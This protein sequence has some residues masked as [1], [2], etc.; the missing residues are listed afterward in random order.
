MKKGASSSPGLQGRGGLVGGGSSLS[1]VVPAGEDQLRPGRTHPQPGNLWL[2]GLIKELGLA[3]A[4]GNGV[5]PL[6]EEHVRPALPSRG[7]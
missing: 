4:D 3:E 1:V 2:L 5:P 7:Q 6:F